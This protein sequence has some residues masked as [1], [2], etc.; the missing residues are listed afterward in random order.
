V[1]YDI[2]TFL[3]GYVLQN[4][5]DVFVNKPWRWLTISKDM[6]VNEGIRAREVRLIDQNGNW[7]R[8][9]RKHWNQQILIN[10]K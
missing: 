9:L 4:L 8:K 5:N 7:F 3:C 10:N 1:L 2:H 6:M